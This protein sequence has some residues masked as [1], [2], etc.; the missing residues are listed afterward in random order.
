M[1]VLFLNHTFIECGVYQFGKRVY[2]LAARSEKVEYIYKNVATRD[3]YLNVI[4]RLEPEYI[5][6]NYHTDRM[7]WLKETDITGNKKSKHYFVFHDGG[8]MKNYDKYLFFGGY[9][10]KNDLVPKDKSV[11]LP[12]PIFDYNGNYPK[13]NVITIGSFGFAFIHKRFPE[14]VKLV[15]SS[16]DSAKIN[17]HIPNPYFGNTKYN[18]QSDIIKACSRNNTKKGISL[19]VET[20]FLDE[21]GLLSFLAGNDINIFYYADLQSLGLSS[22]FDYALSVKRPIGI[23]DNI[24]FRHVYS[25]ELDLNSNS[26]S[27]I[28][29]RGTEPLEKLYKEWSTNNFT[30]QMEKLFI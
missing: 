29:D 7:P 13:N 30:S 21:Y 2:E 24:M 23:V 12:R 20:M 15:N 4:N 25:K 11:L 22:V 5:I 8:I 19:N 3:E 14:L 26:I 27:Q 1:S 28:L 9:D 16:F 10:P 17:L 18:K 6:Y